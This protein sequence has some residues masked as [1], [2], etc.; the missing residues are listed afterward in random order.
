MRHLLLEIIEKSA[1]YADIDVNVN[2]SIEL[3][4]K[5]N[6]ISSIIMV[7]AQE[8]AF[9]QGALRAGIPLSV[10][11]GETNLSDHFSQKYINFKCNKGVS[12]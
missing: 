6:K 10:I 3:Y 12:K 11:D 1:N 9:R 8:L 5:D 7:L 2:Q 4:C